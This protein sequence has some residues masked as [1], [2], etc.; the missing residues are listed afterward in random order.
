MATYA[1]RGGVEGKRRLDL[2]AQTVAGTTHALLAEVAVDQAA[3]A[4]ISAAEPGA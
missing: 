4:S 2:L 3:G 1:I